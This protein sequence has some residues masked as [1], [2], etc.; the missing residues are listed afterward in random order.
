MLINEVLTSSRTR[1]KHT[2][3]HLLTPASTEA[4]RAEIIEAIKAG[5]IFIYPTD[6]IYGLGCNALLDKSVEK[7]RDLK[8]RPE[9]A[10]SIIAPNKKWITENCIVKNMS[11]LDILP[12]PVTL[13]LKQRVG[14]RQKVDGQKTTKA[15][16]LGVRIPRHW[17]CDFIRQAGVPF[18]T[19][20]VNISGAPHMKSLEDVP[21]EILDRVDYVIYEGPHDSKP[22]T[23]IDLT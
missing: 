20:S 10:F 4:N 22:S 13:I 11:D 19:T 15:G 3:I 18:I 12:G 14:G 16:T 21:K 5:A 9:K 8:H 7:I 17:F 23:K 6:T 1:S 2:A